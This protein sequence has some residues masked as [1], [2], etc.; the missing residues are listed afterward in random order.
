MWTTITAAGWTTAFIALL[1]AVSLALPNHLPEAMIQGIVY[2]LGFLSYI[3]WIIP[4][5]TVADI[6]QFLFTYYMVLLFIFLAIEFI[7][8]VSGNA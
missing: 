2:I 4:L 1:G 7:K 3:S 8:R 5:D 6:G